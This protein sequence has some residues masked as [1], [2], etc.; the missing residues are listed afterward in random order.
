MASANAWLIT[1]SGNHRVAVG[2]F[3]MI[4]V[5]PDAPPL[6]E[7]PKTPSYCCHVTI[8]ERKIVPVMDLARRLLGDAPLT[9]CSSAGSSTFLAVVAHQ[10]EGRFQ[11][12][13]LLLNRVPARVRVDDDQACTLPEQLPGWRELAL[14]CFEHKEYGPIPILDLVRIFAA[15]T[16][17]RQ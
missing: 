6:F 14:S 2:E 3:E 13:A 16:R 8:W 7:V 4:H 10:T 9:E 11:Y 5:I 15:G 12:G 17:K 1:L